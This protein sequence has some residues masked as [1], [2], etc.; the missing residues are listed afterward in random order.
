MPLVI[1]AFV[2]HVNTHNGGRN[3]E[4]LWKNVGENLV[5]NPSGPLGSSIFPDFADPL[6]FP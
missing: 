3:S 1:T 4:S 6:T 5:H 2:G